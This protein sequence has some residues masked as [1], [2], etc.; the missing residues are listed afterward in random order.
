MLKNIIGGIIMM[1]LNEIVDEYLEQQKYAIKQRT[2]LFYKQIINIHILD[3][4]GEIEL[5]NLT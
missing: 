3:E 4:I 1:K 5:D 2:N